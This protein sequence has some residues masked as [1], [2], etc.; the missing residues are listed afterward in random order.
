MMGLTW[1]QWSAV[2][3]AV[4]VAVAVGYLLR[5]LFSRRSERE[6]TDSGLGSVVT[7]LAAGD[8][9]RALEI[10]THV[11]AGNT[12]DLHAYI[13][14]GVLFR[15]KGWFNRAV[16]V[17]RR[18]LSRSISDPVVQHE[19]MIE[20]VRDFEEAGLMDR[21]EAAMKEVLQS[22]V[23]TPDDYKIL[24]RLYENVGEWSRAA[25]AWLKTGDQKDRNVKIAYLFAMESQQRN[26]AGDS[27]AA[28]KR[29]KQALKYDPDN[30][31]A[32]LFAAETAARA[33]KL[34]KAVQYYERL[35]A[36]RP[37]LTGVIGDSIEMLSKSPENKALEDFFVALMKDQMDRPRVAVRYAAYLSGHGETDQA[38]K[39]LKSID[40]SNLAPEMLLRLIETAERVGETQ[41]ALTLSRRLLDRVVNR[42]RFICS[43][44]GEFLPVPEWRCPKCKTWGSVRSRT[45]YELIS[46]E[47][48][49]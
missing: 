22:K 23:S 9:E 4:V 17:H 15:R 30:P 46:R 48:A 32:L 27:K 45:D 35:Q 47:K 11:V 1:I 44:C 10:L 40:T 8:H 33:G 34:K 29:L 18:F 12:E 37:D 38:V 2:S 6:H 13:T 36:V 19:A 24:A 21:A 16:D 49:E 39:V 25:E 42:D 43:V 28:A 20:L 5:G 7:A 41:T 26:A 3:A 31:A 14:L